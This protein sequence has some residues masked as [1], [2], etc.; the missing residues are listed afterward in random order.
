MVG[1]GEKW[2]AWARE[3]QAIGQTG[4]YFSANDF[5]RQRYQ[6]LVELSAE[7]FG[8]YTGASRDELVPL[9][10]DQTGYATP[11]VD[12]RAAVFRDGKLLLVREKADGGWSMPGGW[13]DVNEPPSSVAAREVWEESGFQV[14]PVKLIGVFEANHDRPPIQVFHAYKVAFLCD[15]LGGEARTSI[16]TTGVDFFAPDEMPVFSF[17]RT[18]QRLVAEAFEHLKDPARPSA[19]D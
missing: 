19:F 7:V 8:E 16:E 13:A 12:V 4:L 1:S 14:K 15:L 17:E 18:P 6:R 3:I 2:L 5:D 10:L 9:F 11:K